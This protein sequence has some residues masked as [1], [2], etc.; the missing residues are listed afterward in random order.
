MDRSFLTNEDV[1]AASRDFVCIRCA[2]YEDAEEAEYL[3]WI[4]TGRS[5]D[6]EN[7]VFCILSPDGEKKLIRGG[8]GP[9]Q[10][11]GARD[12]AQRMQEIAQDYSQVES[13]EALPQL[14]NIRLGL[15]V[16]ACDNLPAVLIKAENEKQL[17]AMRLKL[18]PVAWDQELL[19]MY[20]F[21]ST[22]DSQELSM[23][24]KLNEDSSG[25]V[26]VAPDDYGQK[27]EIITQLAADA[28]TEEL[29]TALVRAAEDFERPVK[30]HGRHVRAGR[31]NGI[32]WETEIPVT[33]AQAL[34]AKERRRNR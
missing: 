24:E 4:F 31:N 10:F 11:R 19:G 30:S 6:L 12:M 34:R 29:K 8:R 28:T 17:D 32:E 13:I 18:A 14:K 9:M 1:I 25:F 15:N 7:T 5:G 3:R 27:A 33:D 23:I 20:I 22:T 2:T 21:F 16:A 26:I